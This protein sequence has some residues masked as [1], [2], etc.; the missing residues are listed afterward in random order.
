[1]KLQLLFTQDG[2]LYHET[3]GKATVKSELFLNTEEDSPIALNEKL[4][5]LLETPYF[6]EIEVFSA[7]N[8]FAVMPA[9]FSEHEKGFDLIRYNAN[10]SPE[11]EELMLAI[12]PRFGVQFYYSL[13]KE[14]YTLIKGKNL[15]TKFNFSGEK[16]LQNIE[17]KKKQEIHI[18]LYHQ[19][20]EFLALHGKKLVL[21]NN[22]DIRSEVD[23]LY[24]VM[25]TLSQ[26]KFDLPNTY[27]FVYGEIQEN[28]TFISE[29]QKFVKHL[30]IQ[31]ENTAK[32]HFILQ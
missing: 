8:H 3:K 1:M 2:L 18:H 31:Y 26:I 28:E 13:P 11:T 14:Y 29:L 23:F 20:C 21:Y 9:G 4:S 15:P 32:K 5:Q 12:N 19:Q 22:L 30:R 10:A 17:A 24:F 7:I 6:R 27:F 25:F 16:F